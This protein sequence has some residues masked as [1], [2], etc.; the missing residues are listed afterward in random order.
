MYTTTHVLTALIVCFLLKER[1]SRRNLALFTLGSFLPDLDH[2]YMHRF[3]MHNVFFLIASSAISRSPALTLGILLHFLEDAL[4]SNLNTLLHPLALM[5]FGLNQSWLYSAEA[6]FAVAGLFLTALLFREKLILERRDKLSLAKFGLMLL[7]SL[8]FGTGKAATLI[9]GHSNIY[10][11][12]CG[13]FAGAFLLLFGT[14]ALEGFVKRLY[15][16][17]S[18]WHER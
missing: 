3:L 12:Q 10:I 11:I 4:S 17:L 2:L 9:L 14:F 18:D 15:S 8:S 1:F 5:D 7:G 6:N 13:R 16:W